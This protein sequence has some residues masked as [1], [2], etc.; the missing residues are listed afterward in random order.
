MAI[1]MYATASS[2]IAAAIKIAIT[3]TAIGAVYG[4]MWFLS[5][6]LYFM[7]FIA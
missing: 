6:Y 4:F 1:P 7:L 5:V 2:P 3:D